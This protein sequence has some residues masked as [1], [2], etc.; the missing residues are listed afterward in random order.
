MKRRVAELRSLAARVSAIQV[1]ELGRELRELTQA[2]ISELVY[3]GA[4]RYCHG[5]GHRYQHI[6]EREYIAEAAKALDDGR[7]PEHSDEGGYG[8]NGSLRPDEDCPWCFGSGDHWHITDFSKASTAARRLVRGI[9]KQG[10]LLLGRSH[11]RARS[12]A[13]AFGRL[14]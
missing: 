2:D 6:D 12:A 14:R 5:D 4:C 9:G 1:G 11:G 3:R 7:A 13:P 10:E 8:Y